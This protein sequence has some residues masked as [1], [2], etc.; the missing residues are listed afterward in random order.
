MGAGVLYT[1]GAGEGA[2][3]ST[4]ILQGCENGVFKAYWLEPK[5][6]R[7]VCLACSQTPIEPLGCAAM[8]TGWHEWL[9]CALSFLPPGV[10]WGGLWACA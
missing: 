5:S 10:G 3:V 7:L 4:T 2:Q 6:G 1:I 8:H 9:S